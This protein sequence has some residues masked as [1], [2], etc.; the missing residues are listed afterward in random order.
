MKYS[1]P[2][3]FLCLSQTVVAHYDPVTEDLSIIDAAHPPAIVELIMPS[4]SQSLT[5]LMLL[6]N[7]PGPHPTIFLLHGYPGNEKNLDLAQTLR[8]AGFNV[9]F[10]HYRG[11]WGSQG[12]YSLFGQAKDVQNV[13]DHITDRAK[14]LR[15]DTTKMSLVG[16]SMGGFSALRTASQDDRVQ[17]VVGMA[18]AN[19]G[20]YA[21]RDQSAREGFSN[22]TD[23]LIM[24]SGYN[25][26]KALAEIKQNASKLD[27]R[28]YGSGLKGKRVFLIT[29]A[30]DTVVPP[31]VQA[32]VASAYREA[33]IQVQESIIPGDHSFSAT[34]IMLQR[35]VLAWLENNCS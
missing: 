29:G 18:A 3:L 17:C 26:D 15:V 1:I 35:T 16:H 13:I 30:E 11:A 28:T 8:R 9:V 20:T 21:N 14:E 27:L 2:L 19:L 22:Y 12:Q 25:G 10:F 31:D 7:G 4:E 6:A 32:S 24:L 23:Q 5:G 34:R 33:Q